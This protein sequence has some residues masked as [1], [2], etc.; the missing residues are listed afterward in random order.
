MPIGYI[1]AFVPD[2]ASEFA[3]LTLSIAPCRSISHKLARRLQG[4][5]SPPNCNL[6]VMQVLKDGLHTIFN[7]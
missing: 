1:I 4:R 5:F 6:S 7:G 3:N 2:R